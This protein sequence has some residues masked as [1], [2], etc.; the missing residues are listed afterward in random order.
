MVDD[1]RD[2]LEVVRLAIS[3]ETDWEVATFQSVAAAVATPQAADAVLLDLSV[4]DRDAAGAVRE[5]K[6]AT[7]DAAIVLM[8]GS[9]LPAAEVRRIGA[10]GL[11]EKPFDALDLHSDLGKLLGWD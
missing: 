7:A 11:I 1:E 10:S 5:L 3:L 4:T 9:L 6:A 8:T 2:I